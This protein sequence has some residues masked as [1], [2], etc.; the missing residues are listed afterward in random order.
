VGV[1][2]GNVWERF[3]LAY[4]ITEGLT[5]LK[6]VLLLLIKLLV[7][8]ALVMQHLVLCNGNTPVYF[9]N[10]FGDL[11]VG[12]RIILKCTL[13]KYGEG[14]VDWIHLAQYRS[15]GRAPMNTV[16]NPRIP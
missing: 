8:C 13:E 15:H 2:I 6:R 10:Q 3:T 5:G 12:G 9:F 11:D 1:E 7:N 14:C 16:M 4:R